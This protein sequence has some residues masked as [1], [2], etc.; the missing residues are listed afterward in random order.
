MAVVEHHRCVDMDDQ[1]GQ[2]PRRLDYR[3]RPDGVEPGEGCDGSV[4]DTADQ[5]LV[6]LDHDPRPQ[7][8]GDFADVFAEALRGRRDD[9]ADRAGVLQ[10][11]RGLTTLALVLAPGG[12]DAALTAF[13]KARIPPALALLSIQGAGLLRSPDAM[14]RVLSTLDPAVSVILDPME[15]NDSGL[16][17]WFSRFGAEPRVTVGVGLGLCRWDSPADKFWEADYELQT[18]SWPLAESARPQVSFPW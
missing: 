16:E 1:L 4:D 6:D 11:T 18:R 17:E 12:V 14:R 5:R 2:G 13:A 8:A 3:D 10:H 15:E 9:V 7:A